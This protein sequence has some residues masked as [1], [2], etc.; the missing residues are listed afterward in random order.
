MITAT[1]GH[2]WARIVVVTLMATLCVIVPSQSTAAVRDEV[3]VGGYHFHSERPADVVASYETNL[4]FRYVARQPLTDGTMAIDLPTT[5]W[6][7]TLRAEDL[8]EGSPDDRGGVVVRPAGPF[9]PESGDCLATSGEAITW[10]VINTARLRR[11][12]VRHLSCEP[13]QQIAVRMFGIEAPQAVGRYRFPISVIDADGTHRVKQPKLTVVR[14]PRTQ[15]E[16]S[17]D[18]NPVVDAPTVVMVRALRPNGRVDAGYRGGVALRLQPHDCTFAAVEEQVR[19]FTAAE[20]GVKLI[21]VTFPNTYVARKL[22]VYD[23]ATKARS[24]TS[25]AFTVSGDP[26]SI[27]CPISFH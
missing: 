24:G 13:G 1:R 4:V 21:D 10:T 26:E 22:Q 16:I 9:S 6:R 11:V 5:H 25:N 14:E 27:V 17:V 19:D 15:L 18:P 2:W 23:V 20:A 7:T 12:T 3:T 8:L